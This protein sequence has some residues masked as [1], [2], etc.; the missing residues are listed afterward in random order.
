MEK[1]IR[2]FLLIIFIIG[3]LG[4]GAGLLLLEHIENFLQWIPIALFV[5]GLFMLGWCGMARRP[6]SIRV[7]PETMIELGLL[8]LALSYRHPILHQSIR[9]NKNTKP[10]AS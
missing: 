9:E 1:N 6:V 4:S 7:F 3:L 2:A 10:E 5:A 8:G